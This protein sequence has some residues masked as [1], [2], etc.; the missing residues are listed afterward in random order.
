MGTGSN[1]IPIGNRKDSKQ[2]K[3]TEGEA[4]KISPRS[5]DS[6]KKHALKKPQISKKKLAVDIA[7]IIETLKSLVRQ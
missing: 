5:S 7:T 1:R 3:K 2:A 4:Y 6:T